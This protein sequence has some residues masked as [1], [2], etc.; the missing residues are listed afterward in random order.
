[1]TDST[2][3]RERASMTYPSA[4]DFVRSITVRI[5]G[6]DDEALI[7]PHALAD[8]SALA[9]QPVR[10]KRPH[11][12]QPN[13]SGFHF[14]SGLA[15]HVWFE[16][17]LE[18]QFVQLTES[19]STI[20]QVVAQPFRIEWSHPRLKSHVPDYLVVHTSGR[21][22]I[23][24]VKP[25]HRVADSRELFDLVDGVARAVRV[26]SEVFTGSGEEHAQTEAFLHRFR[27][28][29]ADVEQPLPDRFTLRWVYEQH[30]PALTRAALT[31]LAHRRVVALDGLSSSLTDDSILVSVR[32]QR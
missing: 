2:G 7:D 12:N 20:Q 11:K 32:G 9:L 13:F 17:R 31:E 23:V 4:L 18:Q 28:Q 29:P 27:T 15:R 25:P 22:R 16:S 3:L 26:E 19:D 24:N 21:T 8:L 14:H 10:K 1:M 6:V 5:R 30:D